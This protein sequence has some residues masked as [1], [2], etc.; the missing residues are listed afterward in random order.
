MKRTFWITALILAMAGIGNIVLA[1]KYQKVT[2]KALAFQNVDGS[3][4]IRVYNING[5]VNVEGTNGKQMELKSEKIIKA[6]SESDKNKGVNEVQVKT[7]KV[8]NTIL[9]YVDA[10][11]IHMRKEGD[12]I[13]YNVRDHGQDYQYQINFTI[14]I[15]RNTIVHA[16]TINNGN[17]SVSNVQSKVDVRNVNGS[18]NLKNIA[19]KTD[20]NT[21]NG[22]IKATY[23]SNPTEESTF[24]TVNGNIDAGFQ[25]DLSADLTFKTLNGNVYTNFNNAKLIP[26]NISKSTSKTGRVTKY[27]ISKNPPLRIGKGGPQFHFHTLNG[28]IYIREIK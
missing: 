3:Q 25:K 13:Q 5:N 1:Q 4:T 16:S 12:R 10:P 26:A 17:V 18:I 8:G 2:T 15:P 11:F 21:V 22:K 14:K 27:R 6:N 9:V 20:A 19:G 23:T 7:D 28:N 24:R